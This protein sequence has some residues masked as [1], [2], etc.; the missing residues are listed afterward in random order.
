M[1]W[2]GYEYEISS[3]FL[4][5]VL[6][7]FEYRT[8]YKFRWNSRNSRNSPQFCCACLRWMNWANS[9]KVH[10]VE[11][12][13]SLS[14]VSRHDMSRPGTFVFAWSL[15]LKHTIEEH[16]TKY[17]C[18]IIRQY[19]EIYSSNSAEKESSKLQSVQTVL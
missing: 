3:H 4:Q 12:L 9:G 1:A 18:Y 11:Q 16:I 8:R 6:F 10:C 14:V 13:E 5:P 17:L 7:E 19:L 2:D 15:M